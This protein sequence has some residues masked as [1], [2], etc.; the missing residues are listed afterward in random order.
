[1]VAGGGVVGGG[2]V[3]VGP[4]V[5][6]KLR[7]PPPPTRGP[8]IRPQPPLVDPG[9]GGGAPFGVGPLERGPGMLGRTREIIWG[10]VVNYGSTPPCIAITCK[11]SCFAR[12]L[13]K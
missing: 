4:E 2:I 1:V 11:F 9:P 3:G 13:C 5:T 10:G 6:Y 7:H 8:T 12:A